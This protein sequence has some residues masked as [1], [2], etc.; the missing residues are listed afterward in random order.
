MGKDEKPETTADI[1]LDVPPD[2]ETEIRNI[3]R[4]HENLCSG[5]PG[6]IN[7]TQMK[8]NLVS[9]VEPF[10]SL[11]YLACLKK[12]ELKQAELYIKLKEEL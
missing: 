8:I 7:I 11:P 6:E 10:K 2:M 12:R 4:K 3:L 9:D 5:Q 1:P